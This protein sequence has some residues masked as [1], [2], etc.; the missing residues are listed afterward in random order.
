MRNII[1]ASLFV[2]LLMPDISYAQDWEFKTRKTRSGEKCV[3][4]ESREIMSEGLSPNAS[5]RARII[6][7]CCICGNAAKEGVSVKL[8]LNNEFTQPLPADW[9]GRNKV[10]VWRGVSSRP[11]QFHINYEEL[12]N[13][14]ISHASLCQ[15]KP[16]S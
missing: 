9:N 6:Y 14:L 11:L 16:V 1:T 2:F 8:F 3:T 12:L 10:G 13:T 5:V 15:R 7:D 4:G